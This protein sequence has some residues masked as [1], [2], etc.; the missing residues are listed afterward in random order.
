MKNIFVSYSEEDAEHEKWVDYLAGK[1]KER[2]FYADYI[3]STNNIDVAQLPYILEKK[4]EKADCVLLICTPV[5]KKKADNREC[6]VGFETNILANNVFMNSK[7]SRII[8][9]IRA[10]DISTSCPDY[11]VGQTCVFFN[12]DSDFNK[13][14]EKL[15]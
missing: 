7:S 14:F 8:P 1:L 9:L 4:I 5:Y 12:N 13:S 2:G 6:G 3:R 10:G 11:I 15:I